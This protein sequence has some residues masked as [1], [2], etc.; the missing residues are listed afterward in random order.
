MSPEHFSDPLSMGPAC[1]IHSLGVILFQLLSGKLPFDPIWP[2]AVS[3]W[4]YLSS[5]DRPRVSEFRPGLDPALDAICQKAMAR[6]PEKRYSS[7]LA[8]AEELDRYWLSAG[9][10]PDVHEVDTVPNSERLIAAL[11]E[12]ERAKR[13]ADEARQN[14]RAAKLVADAAKQAANAAYLREQAAQ[15]AARVAKQAAEAAKKEAE[16][17]KKKA[18]EATVS[19]DRTRAETKKDLLRTMQEFANV[20]ALV[21]IVLTLTVGAFAWMLGGSMNH[22]LS[23]ALCTMMIGNYLSRRFTLHNEAVERLADKSSLSWK[24][25]WLGDWGDESQDNNAEGPCDE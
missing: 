25:K 15:Q 4:G 14:E 7:M 19:S 18:E 23:S 11:Q 5:P 3:M 20:A 16:E 10:Q 24:D 2:E 22:I 9:F 17:A 21:T 6:D 1:D 8:F 13:D 12:A